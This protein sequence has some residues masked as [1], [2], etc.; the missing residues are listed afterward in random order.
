MSTSEEEFFEVD[1]II[2][3]KIDEVYKYIFI[4][5]LDIDKR[6]P[7]KTCPQCPIEKFHLAY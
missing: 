1:K 5:M 7:V 6:V 2:D 4:I 3:S